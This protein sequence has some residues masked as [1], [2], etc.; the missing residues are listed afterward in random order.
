MRVQIIHI[1]REANQLA[2]DIANEA[3][4]DIELKQFQQF[5]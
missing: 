1:F 5:R 2:D 3:T 4:D